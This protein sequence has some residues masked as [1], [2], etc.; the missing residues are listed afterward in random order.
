VVKKMKKEKIFYVCSECGYQSVRWVG[1]CPNCG[2]WNSFTEEFKTKRKTSVS[3]VEPKKIDEITI[4]EFP[5]IKTGIEEFDRV[6]GGGIVKGSLLLLAGEPGVGKST[7][8][9]AVAGKSSGK[10]KKVLYISGE[11]SFSQIKMR[12]DRLSIH[13]PN[14]YLLASTEIPSMRESLDKIKPDIVIVDSIQ[15]TFDPDIPTTPGS[16]TQIRESTNFFMNFAK[17]TDTPVFLIG[18]IT[19]EGAIA[20]PKILEHIV[21]VVLYFE[22]ENRSSLRILRGIKNRFGSTTEIGVFSMEESGLKEIPEASAV[23]L[24]NFRK[25]LPGAVI[26]PAQ[27]G[28]RTILVEIQSLVAPTYYGIPKRSVTGLDYN[29]ISLVI[30]VLEKKL[31][32]NFGT[33]DVYV[34]V[35]GGLKIEEPGCDLP[36]AIACVSSLKDISP[37][38]ESIYMGEIALTGEIRP[39]NQINHR[40]KESARLGFKKAIIP[41]ENA[42]EVSSNS[43]EIFPV[44]WLNEAVEIS[45][46]Q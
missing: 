34:N 42:K 16:V 31:H 28:T 24:Q 19:K 6:L 23:F 39:V 14:L 15:A 40:I 41:A 27:E 3:A 32:F 7:L 44:K 43:M 25:T 11:E 45:L 5:R 22:G 26:F 38:G 17:K 30:A 37:L 35:G 4:E 46:T 18:H 21:D 33:Q 1:K 8:L 20:G 2:A 10:D 12:A 13:S 9:L 29:R 36:I